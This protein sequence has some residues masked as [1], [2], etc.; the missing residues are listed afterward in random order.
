MRSE[1]IILRE[2][3]ESS[4]EK[5]FT[6]SQ[7]FLSQKTGVSLSVVNKTIRT[8]SNISGVELNRR[9]FNVIDSQRILL[10][11]ATRRSLLKDVVYSTS[12][13][14]SVREIEGE[15]PEGIAFTAFTAYKL[16]FKNVPAD[17][18]E[19]YVYSTDEAI[20]EIQKRFT[21]KKG[22]RNL[23]VLKADPILKNRINERK[24]KDNSVSLPQIF[25]DLWNI[26]KWYSKEFLDKISMNL[27]KIDGEVQAP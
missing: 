25:V 10:Y 13:E 20:P 11:W 6:F 12:V 2:I 3:L 23:F 4:L 16:T 26:N 8:L 21:A 9:G 17:Y 22:I 5:K 15:M 7:S 1:E 19:V 24:L 14:E 18:S 27:A